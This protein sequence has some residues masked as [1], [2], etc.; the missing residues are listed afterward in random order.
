MRELRT[1]RVRNK[2]HV[3]PY[4]CMAYGNS[5]RHTIKSEICLACIGRNY[6][7]PKQSKKERKFTKK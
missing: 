3:K 7:M 5:G 6:T 4:Y 2:A 1:E